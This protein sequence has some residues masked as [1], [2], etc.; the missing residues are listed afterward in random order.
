[1]TETV[2]LFEETEYEAG[3]LALSKAIIE[4]RSRARLVSRTLSCIAY[5]CKWCSRVRYTLIHDAEEEKWVGWKEGRHD[6]TQV[7]IPKPLREHVVLA[8]AAGVAGGLKGRELSDFVARFVGT[9]VAPSTLKKCKNT[10]E[11]FDFRRMWRKIPSVGE[12]MVAAGWRYADWRQTV[13]G[14]QVLDG[15]AFELP[16]MKFTRRPGFLGIVFIDG[17]HMGD[18]M[19]SIMVAMV[20]VTADH[21]ILPLAVVIGAGEDKEAYLRLFQFTKDSLPE[22]FVIMS[23]QSKAMKSAF[24]EFFSNRPGVNHLPCFFHI[25][26]GKSKQVSWEVRQILTADHPGKYKAALDL[27]A[28]TRPCLYESIREHLDHV[29]F[30]SPNYCGKFEFIADSPI[31]SFNAA[32]KSARTAEPLSLVKAIVAF[33][34]SQHEKQI[35]KL[36]AAQFCKS[37]SNTIQNR[38]EQALKMTVIREKNNIYV[39]TELNAKGKAVNYEVQVEDGIPICC[40][41]GYERLGIPCRHQYALEAKDNIRL[42]PISDVYK[43]QVIQES[44]GRLVPVTL[45]QLAEHEVETR[46]PRRGQGRPKTQRF[47]P[48]SEYLATTPKCKCH[49]CGERGHTQRSKKCPLYHTRDPTKKPATKQRSKSVSATSVSVAPQDQDVEEQTE[50]HRRLTIRLVMHSLQNEL[51]ND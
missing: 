1:M 9:D 43:C 49:A 38:R 10:R 22:S 51:S 50:T 21:I 12:N 13:N 35:A 46:R 8:V 48:F 6:E 3:I 47:R 24:Q 15:F 18:T 40:C 17:A 4:D 42:P 36:P 44:L 45:T 31:E 34:R 26:K 33:Y 29:S 23:D 32:M 25:L 11:D 14:K 2:N 16:T 28:A 5:E 30:M 20:T 37:C 27:F 39:I 41:R 19:K 7:H